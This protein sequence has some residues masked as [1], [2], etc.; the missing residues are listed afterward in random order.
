MDKI[1]VCQICQVC[2]NGFIIDC[3]AFTLI[4]FHD[5][6]RSEKFGRIVYKVHEQ[7]VKSIHIAYLVP[8]NDIPQEY[9]ILKAGHIMP[10]DFL[11][12]QMQHLRESAFMQ[13]F[14]I[15]A[16]SRIFLVRPNPFLV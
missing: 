15:R 1:C 11:G 7:I 2:G 14:P 4:V 13:V 10:S 3:F 16:H 6:A 5:G 12:G 9:G 8:F